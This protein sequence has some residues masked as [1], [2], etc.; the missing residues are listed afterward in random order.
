[1]HIFKNLVL[2][3]GLPLSFL[4]LD[5]SKETVQT[6]NFNGYYTYTINAGGQEQSMKQ[7]YNND[8]DVWALQMNSMGATLTVIFPEGETQVF[9]EAAGQKYQIS[10]PAAMGM[11]TADMT[12]TVE[13]KLT[14]TSQTMEI[15]GYS[16][17][18]YEA[19][20]DGENSLLWVSTDVDLKGGMFSKVEG[21]D[22]SIL[23]ADM[24]A[25]EGKISVRLTAY[26]K[27]SPMSLDPAEYTK[28]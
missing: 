21:V 24:E 7:Y 16:C 3:L 13:G 23:G 17:T 9:T 19:V 4:T 10:N 2:F 25:T 14:K 11:N 20:L 26:E 12:P 1:M 28:M 27:D 18:G 5:A 15:M 8:S 6:Y 22:G